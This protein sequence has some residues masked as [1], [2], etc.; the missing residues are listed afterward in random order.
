MSYGMQSTALIKILG[1]DKR[2][3]RRNVQKRFV[4]AGVEICIA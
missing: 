4:G 1:I 3:I 2:R